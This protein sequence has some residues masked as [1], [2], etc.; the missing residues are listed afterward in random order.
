MN[1]EINKQKRSM[2][3]PVIVPRRL[4][5]DAQASPETQAALFAT[6]REAKYARVQSIPLGLG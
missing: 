1:K 4:Y 6:T 3:K 2:T 5:K